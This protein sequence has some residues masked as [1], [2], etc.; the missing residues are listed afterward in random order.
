LAAAYDGTKLT[1]TWGDITGV[2]PSQFVRVWL[3]SEQKLVHKQMVDFAPGAAKTAN[4]TEVRG[5]MGHLI[6]HY[7]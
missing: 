5:D 1:V 4:I 6:P 7:S 3:Y 2:M